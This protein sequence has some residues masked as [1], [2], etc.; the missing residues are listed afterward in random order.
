MP[1]TPA[2]VPIPDVVVVGAGVVGLSTAWRAAQAGRT[3]ALVDP[4]PGNGTSRVAAGMLAPV[5]EA[6]YNERAL[7]R[8]NLDSAARYPAFV[9]ELAELT[10][11]DSGYTSVGTVLAAIDADDLRVA[12]ELHAFHQTLDLP[13]QVLTSR[14]VRGREPFLAPGLRGGLLVEG[15]HSVDPRRLVAALAAACRR[16]GVEFVAASVRGVAA[17]GGRARGVVLGDGTVLAGGQV[18]LAAGAWTG[19]LEGLPPDAFAA[20]RPVKG[21]LLRLHVPPAL[22]PLLT[23][24]VRGLVHGTSIYLVPRE[25]GEL[26][27][28]ATV[29]EQG[30]DTTVTAGAVHDLLRD[31]YELLPALHELPLVE[32]CAGLRPATSDHGPLLGRAHLEGLVLATGHYRNGILLAPITADVVRDVLLGH[33][34]PPVAAPF[35]ADRFS[36]VAV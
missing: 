17:D 11:I 13:T 5:T 8:L 21:Q 19:G 16:A 31:A 34:L 7:L 30:F 2:T 29:E 20:L 32:T 36:T 1:A 12:R 15:D 33:D 14:E 26:V 28:G 23:H 6:A 27:V 35:A 4:A 25:D 18:L 22:R 9:A 24:T 10:G 3:V